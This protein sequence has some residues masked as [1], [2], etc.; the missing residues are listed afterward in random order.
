MKNNVGSSLP[1]RPPKTKSFPVSKDKTFGLRVK[2]AS[3]ALL[4]LKYLMTKVFARGQTLDSEEEVL[5][6]LV[7]QYFHYLRNKEVGRKILNNLE[8]LSI[9]S[10]SRLYSKFRT[11]EYPKWA[12]AQIAILRKNQGLITPRGFLGISET[13]KV[14]N[15]IRVNNRA[16]RSNPKP[17]RF[18]GVGYRDQGTAA[19]KSH[20]GS[21][22]WQEVAASSTPQ[23]S[24]AQ[25]WD[26]VLAEN[27][28]R[29]TAPLQC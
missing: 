19:T 21:P 15:F 27:T 3:E 18:I 8:L 16:L 6:D 24:F 29:L 14:S 25:K 10:L 4:L 23:M 9:F 2:D 22:S 5:Y 1:R 28:F 17:K 26:R 12:L 7:I 13:F 20:D 11:M